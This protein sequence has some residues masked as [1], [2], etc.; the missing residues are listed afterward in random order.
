MVN[1]I[2]TKTEKENGAYNWGKPLAVEVRVVLSFR[3]GLDLMPG[4]A[5]WPVEAGGREL[6][7]NS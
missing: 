5:E 2:T 7:T 4:R 6:S 3:F 1:Q